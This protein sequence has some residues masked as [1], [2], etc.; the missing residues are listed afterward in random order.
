[1]STGSDLVIMSTGSDL[2]ISRVATVSE[3]VSEKNI[4]QGQGKVR[5]FGPKSVKRRFLILVSEN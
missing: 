4:F 1:M 3:K 5:E 2:V